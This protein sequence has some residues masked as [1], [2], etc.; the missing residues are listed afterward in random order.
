M[1]PK[2]LMCFKRFKDYGAIL[3]T[4]PIGD[5]SNFGQFIYKYHICPKCYRIIIEF[6]KKEGEDK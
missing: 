4:P 6:I 1:K 2:C 3:L 5:D